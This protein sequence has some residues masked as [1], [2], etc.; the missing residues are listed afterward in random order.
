MAHTQ[1]Y[2]STLGIS[3]HST[4][5][6]RCQRICPAA[7]ESSLSVLMVCVGRSQAVSIQVHYCRSRN[8]ANL[9][10]EDRSVLGRTGMGVESYEHP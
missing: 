4:L 5:E 9:N 6:N 8:M 10:Q 1:S 7:N 2:R 3:E